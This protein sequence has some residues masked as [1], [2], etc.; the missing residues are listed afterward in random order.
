MSK[1][2]KIPAFNHPID[3]KYWLELFYERDQ[4]KTHQQPA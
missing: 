4:Y 2:I 1:I 3:L